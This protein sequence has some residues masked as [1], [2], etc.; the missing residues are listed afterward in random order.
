MHGYAEREIF[1]RREKDLLLRAKRL[2]RNVPYEIDDEP[3]RCHELARAVGHILDLDWE[4]GFY[5]YADHT[6]LW[7]K[8]RPDPTQVLISGMPNILDVYVPGGLP[9]VQLFHMSTALPACYRRTEARKDIEEG[10]VQEL[11]RIMTK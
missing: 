9:Q 11:I 6:W 10:L 1:S 8:A 3:V 5:G 4:D 7:T 2:L